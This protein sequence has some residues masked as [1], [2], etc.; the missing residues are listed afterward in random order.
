MKSLFL[1]AFA[2]ALTLSARGELPV[3]LA[4]GGTATGSS[5][6]YGS[7]F[8]DASDGNRD[9]HF[10]NGGSVWHTLVPDTAPFYEVD[11]GGTYFLDRV[12]IWPR[13][14]APDQG[15]MENFTL[16]VLDDSGKVVWTADYWPAAAV[17]WAWGTSAMRGVAG[18]KVRYEKRDGTPNYLTFAEFEIQGGKT[19]PSANYARAAGAA[20]TASPAGLGTTAGAA[21]NGDLNGNYASVASPRPVYQSAA[22]AAGNFWQVDLGSARILDSVIV[23]ARQDAAPTGEARLKLLDAA[24]TEIYGAALNLRRTDLVNNGSRFDVSCRIPGTVAAARTVRLETLA[25][26]PLALAEVEV[27]G[28]PADPAPPVLTRQ[29]PAPGA[30]L[31]ELQQVEVEF[32]EDVTGVSAGDLLINGLPASGLTTLSPR[33]HAFTFPQPGNGAV[34]LAFAPGHDITDAAGNAFQGAVWPVTLD[35]TL[36]APRPVITEFL[37]ENKGG[38]RDADGDSSDWIEIY[39]PGP[40]VV[41]LGGWYLSDTPA[42]PAKWRFPGPT[43]LEAGARLVV[44]ASSKDR[45]AAGQPPHTNFKLDPGGESVLLVK[46]DG[47]TVA[48]Q[49]LNYPPQRENVSFGPGRSFAATPLLAQGAAARVLIPGGPVMGWTDVNFDDSAW[50]AGT[51][52]VGFD[53]GGNAAAGGLL[54]WWNFDDAANPA[55]AADSS[56]QGRDGTVANAVFSADAQ[57]RSGKAGDRSLVFNGNGAVT[58]PSAAEGAFDAMADRDAFTLSI[59]AY[60]AATMP[61]ENYLFYAST[62]TG[63][64]GT[65]ALDAHLPWTDSVI[66]FDTA[67]CCGSGETRLLVGEP[68]PSK[69]RGQWNHYV[70]LKNGDTKQIWQNGLLLHEG[71]NTADQTPFRSLFLGALNSAGGSGY[72]GRLDDFALWEGALDGGEIASLAAGTPPP[73]VRRLTPL[74]GTDIG[75][76]MRGIRATAYARVPFTVAEGAVPDL[77]TLKIRY[78]DG[79]VAWLNGVE[80][81]RR[82]A[83]ATPAHDSA[84]AGERPGGG[85][86][87][88]EEI[89][90]TR[91]APLLRS[92]A[93]VL[94]LQGLNH[95]AADGDF[96]L[97]PELSAGQS[98]PDRYFPS[99]TPGQANGAGV[100]GFVSDVKFSPQ[101]GFYDEPVTVTLNCGTPGAMV[102]YTTDSSLPGLTNGQSGPSPLTV[103]VTGTTTLRAAAFQGTLA[104]ANVDTHT[105][106]FVSQV[107]AQKRPPAAPAAWP[108]GF[109]VDFA[110][111][112]RVPGPAPAA[113]YSLRESLLSLPSLSLTTAP[114]DLWGTGG[115][116]ANSSGR[117]RGWERFTSVEWLDPAS[118]EGFHA[119]AGLRLHGNISRNKDFT[120]KHGFSLRFRGEYGDPTLKFPL[121]PGSPVEEF[122][123][124]VLRAGSTDTWPCT[125]WAATG[126]G[127]NGELYQRWNRD[128]ASYLRDQWVRDAHLAMGQEDFR[129]RYCHLY[130]NGSYWGLYNVT[131]S[132]SAAHMAAHFGGPEAEWDTVADFS[133]LHEGSRSAWDQLLQMANGGQLGSDAGLRRVQG[134]AADGTRDPALPRLL[135]VDNLIDYM[136]LH[137][138][139]G[140]D[141]WPN[142]NWW[143]ARRSRSADPEGFRFFSWDQEISNVNAVYGRSSWGPVYAEAEADGTPTRIYAKLRSSPEFRLRFADRAQRHL[144]NDGALTEAGNTARWKARVDE[145]DHALVAES[146]RWGNAQSNHTHPGQPYTREN[147]WLPHLAW[148]A[149]NYWPK[150]PATALTRLRA[151]SLFPAFAAPKLSPHGGPV[152]AVFSTTLS[153]PNTAGGGTLFYTTNGDDPRQWGGTVHPAALNS[154]TAVT[155]TLPAG[156]TVRARIRQGTAWSA[157]TEAAFPLNPD[158][159]HDGMDDAWEAGH[160]LSAEN[161][162]DGAP[163]SDGDGQTNFE[164]YLANTDPR[165]ASS[166]LRLQAETV[167]PATGRILL[168][169]ALQP[170]RVYVI[171]RSASL[172]NASSWVPRATFSP[173]ASSRAVQHSEPVTGQRHFY[174]LRATTAPQP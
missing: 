92:G 129:G 87:T 88:A 36:P 9:G 123:E 147:A 157:L 154:A 68:D 82:N 137:I 120:P 166:T 104:P 94:A 13:T 100:T 58:F 55:R 73:A 105:Y 106:L 25:A 11:L 67:G 118:P 30:L 61:Q 78:D 59:Q 89:D 101:R 97:L 138:L 10:Y 8:A 5:A 26:E 165:A 23:Y 169:F 152:S 38:L 49:I 136:I 124:L 70:F 108:G 50:A 130:L 160:G 131:E 81:A 127:L 84:A 76:A 167:D 109:P 12:M 171:E 24:G 145:I 32:D 128:W 173:E 133:E 122:D 3:N 54:G 148:M 75:A 98:Q 16:K 63:G 141:D 93:N 72:R 60:G 111:D 146:A 174:R 21:N 62:G 34:S 37:A 18:R 150:Q 161:P 113:G 28:P 110:M 6:G 143:G 1:P 90:L 14:D 155:L 74:I 144:F 46:P 7:V 96:L 112:P 51:L 56:G 22:S 20:V 140:A 172:E 159:D 47:L 27:F 31:A 156:A 119:G 52:G 15:T 102:V 57:G 35:T 103:A 48:S 116:Y 139:I 2:V 95:T 33:R 149:A 39:N 91:F 40:T 135:D 162:A 170:G 79:F 151:A 43:L 134:L 71:I 114:A 121:F 163:D 53:T 42:N 126:L 41:N 77:L 132:P 19:Q 66:Y 168:R 164:E 117:G 69:W 17:N 153:N 29:D 99:P 125:E 65:R 45:A 158:L 107:A 85:A 86:L 4:P 115:I 83:P 80:V 44:F 142:H 64:S